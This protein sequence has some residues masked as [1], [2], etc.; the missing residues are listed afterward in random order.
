MSPGLEA[1][2]RIQGVIRYRILKGSVKAF[3]RSLRCSAYH[4]P[5]TPPLNYFFFNREHWVKQCLFILHYE[6]LNTT[7]KITRVLFFHTPFCSLNIYLIWTLL[8]FSIC[9]NLYSEY[10]GKKDK[11]SPVHIMEKLNETR[12]FIISISLVYIFEYL[13]KI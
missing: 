9:L 3:G 12:Q 2:E 4:E 6:L 7:F 11:L 1:W 5:F 10:G 13:N 8:L